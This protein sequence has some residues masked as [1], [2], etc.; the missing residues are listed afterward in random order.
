MSSSDTTSGVTALRAASKALDAGLH[1]LGNA[2]A[3]WRGAA[4]KAT[5]A[6]VMG[7]LIPRHVLRS[8]AAIKRYI[9]RDTDLNDCITRIDDE[10]HR[11]DL[12]NAVSAHVSLTETNQW[13]ARLFSAARNG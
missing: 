9:T 1:P 6:A 7:L 12:L 5:S 10:S 11:Q 4:A 3:T 8:D 2:W 13:G